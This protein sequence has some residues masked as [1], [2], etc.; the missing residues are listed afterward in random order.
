MKKFEKME[1]NEAVDALAGDALMKL[2]HGEQWRTIIWYV[3]QSMALW[4][5]AQPKGK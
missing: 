4:S 1:F 2:I 5:K 3:C